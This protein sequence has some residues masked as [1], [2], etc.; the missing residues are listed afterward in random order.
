MTCNRRPVVSG[1]GP[2]GC[3]RA[4]RGRR[5]RALAMRAAVTACAALASSAMIASSAARAVSVA[6]PPATQTTGAA[7]SVTAA[8]ARLR[9]IDYFPATAGWE[10]MWLRWDP[11]QI[12]ADLGRVAAL[13]ANAVRIIVNAPAFGFPRVNPVMIGR[14]SQTIE[15]A[16]SHGLRIE[17]TLF[18]G[19]RQYASIQ[20]SEAWVGELLPAIRGNSHIVY[21][22]LHNELPAD[23]NPSS[24]AWA[25]A[26]VP[27][28]QSHDGGIPVTVS[29]SISSGTA[30]L[31]ALV[32]GLA[33]TPPDLYDVHYYGN[34]AEA[35]A[36]LA[37]AKLEVGQV[38]M[39]VGETGFATSA[40][41]GWARGLQPSASSLEAYQDYYF[42]TVEF[43]AKA[44][45]LPPAAP[46]ILYDMPGQGSTDWGH[47]V[48]IL[49]SDGRPKPAARTLAGI[50]SGDAPGTW[51]NNGFEQSAG[52]PALPSIWRRWLPGLAQFSVDTTASYSGRASARIDHAA[53][54]HDLGCPGFYV[55]PVLAM[56]GGAGYTASAWVRGRRA[57]GLS[58]VVLDWSDTSGRFV[59]SSVSASLPAGTTGWTR[60][61][62][63]AAPPAGAS[64]VEINLQVCENSGTT[65]FDDVG[66]VPDVGVRSVQSSARGR[67][68]RGRNR[69]LVKRPSPYR[70]RHGHR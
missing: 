27:Y 61:S 68:R 25:Q 40:S 21:I 42:R 46:W 48:G 60:L 41:Y 34:V 28:V 19:W 30:P 69:A 36:V 39:F 45:G 50:F 32:R 65:W 1:P 37:Q 18:D 12:D 26:L 59:G 63:S 10:A 5:V 66:F 4:R 3:G 52:D 35:H 24:L 17:L 62:V 31:Q 2:G 16:A 47:H 8:L 33:A 55:A 38:P 64:S 7:E 23:T 51:F 15:L 44:L 13:H 43:A 14:L 11:A 53:G 56:A 20:E 29:T 49:H 54:D 6:T 58:R 67:G 22:D 9:L 57:S 70:R